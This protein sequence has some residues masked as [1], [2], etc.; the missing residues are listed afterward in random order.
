VRWLLSLGAR[1]QQRAADAA[2]LQVCAKAVQQTLA[3][4]PQLVDQRLQEVAALAVE[5]GLQVA[6]E[7]VGAALEQGHY[8]PTPTVL[9][10][11][12][13]CV[14]GSRRDD[15]VV[16]LHPQDLALVQQG[17]QQHPELAA[18][19]QQA[20]LVADRS[21][22]RGAVRAETDTGRLQY[23]PREALERVAAE[24]RREVAG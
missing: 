21:V 12:R 4:V 3:T 7:I 8:D 5:L 15:L 18:E 22:N 10:C 17:L 24:V 20:R 13:D 19:V 14:H 11:L 2:A 16:R 6:R 9:R 23:D 1:E